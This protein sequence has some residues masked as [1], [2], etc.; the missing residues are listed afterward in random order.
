MLKLLKTVK[1]CKFIDLFLFPVE[2]GNIANL[3]LQSLMFAGKNI[4]H[5]YGV[6]SFQPFKICIYLGSEC[7]EP[8]SPQRP[9][10]WNFYCKK[11]KT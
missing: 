3:V 1:K 8:S 2:D 5:Q 11:P 7:G 9:I 6:L 10:I 4:V